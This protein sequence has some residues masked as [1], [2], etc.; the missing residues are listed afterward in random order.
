MRRLLVLILL[1]LV[2]SL[3]GCG[4]SNETSGSGS[5]TPLDT[6]TI[7]VRHVLERAVPSSIDSFRFSGFDANGQIVFGPDTRTKKDLIVLTGVPLTTR[8]LQIEYLSK[9][10]VVGIFRTEV[11][12]SSGEILKIEDPD[13]VDVNAFG[14]PSQLAFLAQPTVGAPGEV[15]KPATRVAILDS[16]GNL[17]STADSAILLEGSNLT[18]TL[19][20]N[21]VGG[22]ATFSDLAFTQAGTFTL[23]ASSP[24][25]TSATSA[26]IEITA[27][28]A[29]TSL[30]FSVQ[31]VDS[32]NQLADVQVQVL[33]QFGNPFPDFNGPITVALGN[34]PS[35][36]S[37]QGT[38]TQNAVGGVA[39]FAGLVVSRAGMG[40][41]LIAS[42]DG[43]QP[44][45]SQA[46]QIDLGVFARGAY[47]LA[48]PLG[49]THVA[50]L[51][52]G[53]FNADGRT[54]VAL[55]DQGASKVEVL[56]QTLGGDYTRS[57]F[58]ASN[59]ALLA[60]ADLNGD[61]DA[62]LVTVADAS[63]TFRVEVW[64]SAGDGTFTGPT[65]IALP[66]VVEVNGAR[67]QNVTA[68]ELPE[69][70]L[71]G[72][73]GGGGALLTLVNTAGT[74]AAPVR[75]ALTGTGGALTVGPLVGSADP[76]AAVVVGQTVEILTGD[77]A[78]GFLFDQSLPP[79]T[80]TYQP[81]AL[82]IGNL[83]GANDLDLAVL[84]VDG[85]NGRLAVYLNS[86]GVFTQD[87][88][89]PYMGPDALPGFDAGD[90]AV[91]DLNGDG[92]DDLAALSQNDQLLYLYLTDTNPAN[93]LLSV[94][95]QFVPVVGVDL[96]V[97]DLN[98]DGRL[99]V[100]AAFGNG[101]YV[102]LNGDGAGQLLPLPNQV[103][104]HSYALSGDVNQ[105]G[106]LDIVTGST[107][108]DLSVYLGQPD[109]T[110][111]ATPSFQVSPS[112]LASCA[113]LADLNGDNLPD[114][115]TNNLVGPELFVFLNQ[116]GGQFP[117]TADLTINLNGAVS[118][119]SAGNLNDDDIPDLVGSAGGTEFQ[120]A[121]SVSS[122]N[123]ASS[124][125]STTGNCQVAT[126]VDL[127]GSGRD[128][129]ITAELTS[130]VGVYTRDNSGTFNPQLIAVGGLPVATVAGGDLNLDDVPDLAAA[131]QSSGS[132]GSAFALLNDGAG[133]LAAP[134]ALAGPGYVSPVQSLIGDANGDG[135]PDILVA[136]GVNLACSVLEGAGDGTTFGTSP[137]M[138]SL[139]G[140]PSSCSLLLIDLDG[141]GKPEPNAAVVA[142]GTWI[143]VLTLLALVALRLT[144]SRRRRAV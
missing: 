52:R 10:V 69:L 77:G 42:A 129:V 62:D 86:A 20:V 115:I 140:P 114:L 128:Q 95:Q 121:L 101:L 31:P 32:P 116:G 83:D 112:V 24:G 134:V 6:A 142:G 49:T 90:L 46:F 85:V 109:G 17:V 51:A 53:D 106:R 143:S 5:V 60:S 61:G 45:T 19:A 120:V 127:T 59:E 98:H 111:P 82:A 71:S 97:A 21:A 96:T 7:Q 15:L 38:L 11:E 139:G 30:R 138:V 89:S 41:T 130:G 92:R 123:Y 56:L 64:L 25:L 133:S 88:N 43:L 131:T 40:F 104:T 100:G 103:S 39:D 84:A 67:L 28:P 73:D 50:A 2:P 87:A 36:A 117:M 57:S 124:Q 65:T 105:D 35:G 80:G 18:G 9:G 68:D 33:D 23:T 136:D 122:L 3:S 110:F 66:G 48:V 34:N 14:P 126:L 81:Y 12:L 27:L 22:V 94:A 99:D 108:G 1:L 47:S 93:P 63:G 91:G 74:L 58:S 141:D 29:A 132:L 125:V 118:N 75:S 44:A 54:D 107:A 78:G 76:D 113:V 79:L 70:V 16:D 135:I 37:L 144:L 72:A 8:L 137:S 26:A 13:W 55:L 102:R 4:G 119:L